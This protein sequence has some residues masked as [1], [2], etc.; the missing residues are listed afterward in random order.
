VLTSCGRAPIRALYNLI[1]RLVGGVEIV[2]EVEIE[3]E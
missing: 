2:G 3:V 1:A